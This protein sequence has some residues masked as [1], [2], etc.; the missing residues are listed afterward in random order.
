MGASPPEATLTEVI[1]GVA[2]ELNRLQLQFGPTSIPEPG[3][4]T[5]KLLLPASIPATARPP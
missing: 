1:A 5:V 3:N 2:R 4:G